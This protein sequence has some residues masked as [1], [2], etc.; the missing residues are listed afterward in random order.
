METKNFADTGKQ[1]SRLGFGAWQL[2][3][4]NSQEW[5]DPDQDPVRLVHAAIDAE[6]NFFDTAPNYGQGASTDV[7][8]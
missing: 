6:I 7:L 2:G 5:G 4:R 3:N 8:G 1:V